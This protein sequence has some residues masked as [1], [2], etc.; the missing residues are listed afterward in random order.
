M[1]VSHLCMFPGRVVGSMAKQSFRTI[2]SQQKELCKLTKI[3]GQRVP[4]FKAPFHLKLCTPVYK[5]QVKDERQDRRICL[6]VPRLQSHHVPRSSSSHHQDP[7]QLQD[8]Y[9]PRGPSSHLLAHDSSGI[10]TYPQGSSSRLLAHDSFDM[11]RP[12]EKHQQKYPT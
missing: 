8:R 11:S 10:A 5:L 6:R 7:R 1:L 2:I 12:Q 9:V 4:E 3:L